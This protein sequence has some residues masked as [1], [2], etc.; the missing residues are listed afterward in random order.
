MVHMSYTHRI[1]GMDTR[2]KVI[3][4]YLIISIPIHIDSK[5]HHNHIQCI[6]IRSYLL[7]LVPID[8]PSCNSR[9]TISLYI[10]NPMNSFSFLCM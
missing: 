4:E 9:K 7:I 2:E 10:I 6:I 5:F 8:I 1:T 3:S